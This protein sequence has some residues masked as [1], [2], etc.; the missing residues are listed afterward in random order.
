[1][2]RKKTKTVILFQL[3]ILC[4]LISSSFAEKIQVTECAPS[5]RDYTFLWWK[6]GFLRQEKGK[7]TICLQ[8]GYFGLAINVDK[9]ELLSLGKIEDAES[10]EEA[11]K[12]P[13]SEIISLS[14]ADIQLEIIA[15]GVKYNCRGQRGNMDEQKR[16][17]IPYRMI[18][19]GRFMQKFDILDL[20]F[21]NKKGNKLDEKCRL[22]INATP[23]SLSFTLDVEK[24][25]DD[26]KVRIDQDILPFKK[27][28]FE[29][30]TGKGKTSYIV[31]LS[32]DQIPDKDEITAKAINL[33]NGNKLKT[34]YN[35]RVGYL[36]VHVPEEFFGYKKDQ[37][38]KVKVNIENKFK[39]EISLPVIFTAESVGTGGVPMITDNENNPTGIPFQI[40]KNWHDIEENK[41]LYWGKWFRGITILDIPAGKTTDFYFHYISAKWAGLPAVSLSQ[42]CLVGWGVNQQWNQ[43][44]IGNWGESICYDPETALRRSIIDD[45]RPL[46]VTSYRKGQEKWNWTDNFGGGD[47]IVY[48]DD[49]NE[50]QPLVNMKTVY[51]K[52]GPNLIH[53]IFR[54]YTKDKK[55]KAEFEFLTPR[56]D[57]INRAYHKLHLE[58]LEPVKFKRFAVYQ[59]GADRYNAPITEKVAYGNI[60]GLKDKWKPVKGGGKY[61]KQDVELAGKAPWIALYETSGIEYGHYGVL[62]DRGMVVRKW[63]AKIKGK[64]LEKPFASFYGTDWGHDNSNAEITFSSEVKELKPGDFVDA[65][66]EIFL[67][68]QNT[69]DYYGPNEKFRKHLKKAEGTYKPIYRQA[70]ENH[71]EVTVQDGKLTNTYPLEINIGKDQKTKF[72]L[73]GGLAYVPV[74]FI[75]VKDYRDFALYKITDGSKVRI[76]QN[77]KKTVFWQVNKNIKKDS[78][79]ITYNINVDENHAPTHYIFQAVEQ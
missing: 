56:S 30:W 27:E 12:M 18:Y 73:T 28:F 29:G 50:L 17:D 2:K 75:G 22:E 44:A 71:I 62:A 77:Q 67:I 49:N 39:K 32:F 79:S 74:T 4:T 64:K 65:A 31:T 69:E 57:D 43:V 42:L 1:M 45:F 46:M 10:Y 15:D 47:I 9:L 60:D 58:V 5:L 59:L 35:G 33:K 11:V 63:D 53:G 41:A 38:G 13:A 6:N 76:R 70:K 51:K 26:I 36:L 37:F 68:P 8:T 55:I 34:E 23:R 19:N 3:L 7:R 78:Y 21:K 16:A 61:Y 20:V 40:S 25:V 72:T 54:G 14:R 24:Y 48:I 52:I 66:F